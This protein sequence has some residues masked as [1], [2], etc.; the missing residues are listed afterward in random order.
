[1]RLCINGFIYFF[2]NQGIF[3]FNSIA[4]EK[5]NNEE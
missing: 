4:I 2:T 1:M 5:E 3:R